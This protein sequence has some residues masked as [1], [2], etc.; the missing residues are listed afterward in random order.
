MAKNNL[1]EII[2]RY[3][4]EINNGPELEI[5]FKNVDYRNFSIIYN[6]LIKNT[7]KKAY[8]TQ[9]V[10]SIMKQK[11]GCQNIREIH[12]RDKISYKK[13]YNSKMPLL[14]PYY[15]SNQFGLSFKV[16]L[17]LEKSNIKEFISDETAIIRVKNRASFFMTDNGLEWRLD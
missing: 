11:N 12:F 14:V 7:E 9:V 16:S 5:R 8:I 2:D 13:M 17:S 10:G 15:D 1:D 6:Y 4:K 3:K